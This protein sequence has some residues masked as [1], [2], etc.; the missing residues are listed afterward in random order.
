MTDRARAAW[1][2]CLG[3]GDW[4]I[5]ATVGNG[6]DA[7]ALAQLVGPSG[8]V[9]GFDIQAEAIS[10][11]EARLAAAG[12]GN[13]ELF[14]CDHAR[15]R[16]VLPQEA[17]NRVAVVAFNLGYLPGGDHRVITQAPSTLAA[18]D[19]SLELLR[20][21]GLITVIAY[22]GHAGGDDEAQAVR[23]WLQAQPP[24]FIP[25][26]SDD[27]EPGVRTGPWL[28]RVRKRVQSNDSLP[29]V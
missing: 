8:R 14:R 10:A 27:P 29:L 26:E 3:P 23:A 22:P 19:A 28:A 15:M 5:D 13:V 6:H 24:E 1:T 12:I 20:P 21:G 2:E 18:L 16:D 4:A 25:V 9:F 11:T 7:L 17:R